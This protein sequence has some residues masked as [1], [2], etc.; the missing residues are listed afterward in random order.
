MK[1]NFQYFLS[2][3]MV[4][5]LLHMGPQD[6][7]FPLSSQLLILCHLASEGKK[8]QTVP[9]VLDWERFLFLP[10]YLSVPCSYSFNMLLGR[11]KGFKWSSV[12][13]LLLFSE[14]ALFTGRILGLGFSLI[15]S[16]SISWPLL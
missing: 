2:G 13:R 8:V 16:F 15:L 4:I 1:R 10:V 5:D 7:H 9:V 3:M 12:S 14:D 11:G 6:D